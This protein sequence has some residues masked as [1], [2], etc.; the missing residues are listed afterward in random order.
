LAVGTSWL[1][2]VM[3]V[4][5]ARAGLKVLAGQP[6]PNLG[7]IPGAGATQRLPR[8][9]GLEKAWPLLRTGRPV[10]GAEALEMGLIN[11]EVA[12]DLRATAVTY[13]RD[14]ARG[15]TKLQQIPRG[16]IEVKALPD[17]DIGHLSHAVDAVL[18]KAIL[19]G[20]RMPLEEG[21][22]FEA[23]CFGDVCALDDMR[24]GLDNFVQ[25]GP[26]SKAPF[27]HR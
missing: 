11:R 26:R 4:C 15:K 21:L 6:E 3:P 16:P 22:R 12:G 14:A 9:I 10:S 20:A 1:S 17:V 13:A 27:I 19:E 8:L 23:R 18:Q 7:L 24:I 2:L 25:N 5:L